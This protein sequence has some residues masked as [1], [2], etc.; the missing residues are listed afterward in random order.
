MWA[1]RGARPT[2]GTTGTSILNNGGQAVSGKPQQ[3]GSQMLKDMRVIP[4]G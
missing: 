3:V 1:R 4:A 2:H